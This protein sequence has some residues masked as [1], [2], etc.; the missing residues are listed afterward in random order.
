MQIIGIKS[1]E[2]NLKK[3]LFV[4]ESQRRLKHI[5]FCNASDRRRMIKYILM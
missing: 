4:R 2:S 3:E 5:G 1:G